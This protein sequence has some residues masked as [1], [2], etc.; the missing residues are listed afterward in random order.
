VRFV[1][2]W[3][4]GVPPFVAEAEIVDRRGCDR[5]PIDAT[6]SAGA[7][8]LLSYAWP[9][10][11]ERFSRTRSAIALASEAPVVVDSADAGEWLPS[12]LEE[13][14]EGTVLVVFHSVVW[15]YLQE[16][17]RTAVQAALIGAGR[18]AT[19]ETP[20]A[21]L[22]LEPDPKKF[23]PAGLWLTLWD[24]RT[25]EPQETVL[26]TT[27]FHGGAINWVADQSTSRRWRPDPG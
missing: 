20:L 4:G 12:Q 6:V 14:R 17:T 24:G 15:Q 18:A 8:T 26:A 16:E 19:P 1:D 13:R 25:D 27:G 9:Q 5:N 10:P 7:L 2:L 22:R 3:R 21:W 11:T 23:A